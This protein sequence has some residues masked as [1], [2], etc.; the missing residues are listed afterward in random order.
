M[1]FKL[2]RRLRRGIRRS[3]AEDEAVVMSIEHMFVK[4][5]EEEEREQAR[6]VEV[7][8]HQDT[9][10][11]QQ[12]PNEEERLPAQPELPETAGGGG[13][14]VVQNLTPKS[15]T[16]TT[17]AGAMNDDDGGRSASVT[18]GTTTTT[19]TNDGEECGYEEWVRIRESWTKGTCHHT[20]TAEEFENYD[21]SQL[22]NIPKNAYPRMYKMLVKENR[23]LKE[24]L[25]LAD[26]F[27]IIKAG[28]EADG[29]WPT[30]DQLQN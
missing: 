25:N 11:Q 4:E 5:E 14:E 13:G 10:Q 2:F 16:T 29:T 3:A 6:G 12:E 18:S 23:P 26:A 24:P 7:D 30:Q 19:T 8:T 27:K 17:G 1:G 21:K 15:T 20:T 28:W 22:K 9:L